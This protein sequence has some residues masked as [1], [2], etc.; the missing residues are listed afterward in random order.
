MLARAL[1]FDLEA[2]VVT[3]SPAVALALCGHQRIDVQML[4]GRL[5]PVSQT[6][7]GAD[8]IEQLRALRPDAC[9]ISTCGVDPEAGVTLREREEALVVRAMLERSR[10]AVLLASAAKL[11][12]AAAYVVAPAARV[13][14]L[15]TDAARASLD[16]YAALG[17]TL[18]TPEAPAAG[19]P[20]PVPAPAAALGA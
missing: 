18:V 13:D 17:M 14:V 12:S 16:A 4:G 19:A 3:S 1:P 15:V 2:T 8:T 9:L 6:V 7:G 5:D 20:A 10:R 11:A